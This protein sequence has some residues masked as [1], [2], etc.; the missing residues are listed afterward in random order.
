MDGG[1]AFS[2]SR[3]DEGIWLL[4]GPTCVTLVLSAGSVVPG[5]YIAGVPDGI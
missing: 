2:V 3:F 5:K 1:G 4:D